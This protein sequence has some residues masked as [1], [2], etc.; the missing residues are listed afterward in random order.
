MLH[1]MDDAAIIMITIEN[2]AFCGQCHPSSTIGKA[3]LDVFESEIFPR[4]KQLSKESSL[5]RLDRKVKQSKKDSLG[6]A[7]TYKDA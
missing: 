3:E 1:T 4:A 5:K 2:P 7:N 6:Y